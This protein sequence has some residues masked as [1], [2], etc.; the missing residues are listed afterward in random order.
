M[1]M[2]EEFLELELWFSSASVSA[3]KEE[4]LDD[5]RVL[6]VWF[7]VEIL[8]EFD[9]VFG[10]W[11]SAA[12]VEILLFLTDFLFVGEVGDAFRFEGSVAEF[13]PNAA[14]F[15]MLEYAARRLRKE[16]LGPKWFVRLLEEKV[17][18]P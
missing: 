13:F 2:S 5:E 18:Q 12:D 11:R 9:E 8:L 3:E 1:P 4:E 14:A 17:M 16:V 7:D 15:G 10:F 6:V